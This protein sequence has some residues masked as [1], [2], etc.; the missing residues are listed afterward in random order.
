[1]ARPLSAAMVTAL[2]GQVVRPLRFVDLEFDTDPLY[3]WTGLGT[4]SWNG[5]DYIGAGELLETSLVEETAEIKAT[6]LQA[7]L[8]GIPSTLLSVALSEDYQGRPFR[9][10]LGGLTDAG[11]LIVDPYQDFGGRMD[12]MG[13]DEGRDTATIAMTVES[14]AA[15]LERPRVRRYTPEDQAIDYPP[16]QGSPTQRDSFFDQVAQLTNM[17]IAVK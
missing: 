10:Y 2:T 16:D 12:V 13:I 9:A 7:V 11:A 14:Q 4:L 3:L 6:G 1:M 17:E 5:H 8:S 15:D